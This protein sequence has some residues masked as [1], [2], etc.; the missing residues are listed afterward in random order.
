[1]RRHRTALVAIGDEV[2]RETII[3]LLA[4]EDHTVFDVDTLVGAAA[5]ASHRTFDLFVVDPGLLPPEE[6]EALLTALAGSASPPSTVVLSDRLEICAVAARFGV[7]AIR[8]P[9]DLD[10]FLDRVERAR[11]AGAA[12]SMIPRQGR[13]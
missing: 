12:P 1:M 8:E 7:V 4:D 2:L 10:E 11:M 13:G 3:G 5:F 9:F 6:L